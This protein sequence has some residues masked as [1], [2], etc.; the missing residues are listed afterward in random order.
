MSCRRDGDNEENQRPELMAA[1]SST[2]R[3]G[4]SMAIDA[5]IHTVDW[6]A[7][8]G[9]RSRFTQTFV[10]RVSGRR[11]LCRRAYGPMTQHHA[12]MLPVLRKYIG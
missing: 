7:L 1:R 2:V 11:I 12:F 3:M 9:E 10:A 5:L 8:S 4:S 6:P